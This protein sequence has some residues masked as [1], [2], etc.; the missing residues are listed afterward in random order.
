[1]SKR[2]KVITVVLVAV[3]VLTVGATAVVMAQE[4]P[5][6]ETGKQGLLVRVAD[7]LGIPQEELVGA[8]KQAQQEMREESFIRSLDGAVEKGRLTQEEA[9]EIKEWQEQKPEALDRGLM[10][11][12]TF[13]FMAPRARHMLGGHRGCFRLGPPKPSD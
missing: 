7:I 13:G 5:T 10:R 12:G 8:F 9:D 3:L 6:P 4:E 11:R 1:M 2:F